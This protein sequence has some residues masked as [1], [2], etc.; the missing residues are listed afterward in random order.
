M[1]TNLTADERVEEAQ[2]VLAALRIAQGLLHEDETREPMKS[3]YVE[4]QVAVATQ[5][6]ILCRLQKERANVA[7]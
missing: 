4:V 7:A 1:G 3:W 5:E 6:N 2:Q